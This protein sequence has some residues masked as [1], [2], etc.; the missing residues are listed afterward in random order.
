M[1]GTW[2]EEAEILCGSALKSSLKEY[3]HSTPALSSSEV[4]TGNTSEIP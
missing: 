1:I 2:A 4:N 3:F